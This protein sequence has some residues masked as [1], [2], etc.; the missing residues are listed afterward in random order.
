MEKDIISLLC[1]WFRD[2]NGENLLSENVKNDDSVLFEN[3][4]M[5]NLLEK[6]FN[7]LNLI[8]FKLYKLTKPLTEAHIDL[9]HEVFAEM[10]LSSFSSQQFYE[11]F[12]FSDELNKLDYER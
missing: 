11:I 2:F 9:M 7:L 4:T 1:E 10:A 6:V 3:F 8:I 12:Y 5:K